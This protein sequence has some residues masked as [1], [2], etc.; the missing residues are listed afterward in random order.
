[1]G[2]KKSTLIRDLCMGKREAPY[3][4]ASLWFD[5]NRA[6]F[7]FGGSVPFSKNLGSQ[8]FGWIF[9]FVILFIQL[10]LNSQEIWMI[11]K[12]FVPYFT[13]F[14]WIWYD[15]YELFEIFFVRVNSYALQAFSII[16]FIAGVSHLIRQWYVKDID[17]NSSGTGLLYAALSRTKLKPS[18]TFVTYAQALIFLTV[19]ILSWRFWNDP[20]FGFFMIITGI[21]TWSSEF[22]RNAEIDHEK[23]ISVV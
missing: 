4:V 7:T 14:L 15:G 19:G 10:S 16:Y 11:F 18:H 9:F 5:F 22:T 8:K 23:S 13:P 1:M 17:L 12:P 21:S 3:K 6:I 20:Y 2:F